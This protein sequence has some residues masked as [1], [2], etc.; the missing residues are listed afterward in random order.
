MSD[1]VER[2]ARALCRHA[3]AGHF[4]GRD[5]DAY[6]EIYW[7]GHASGA[8]AAVEAMRNPT[9]KMIC[10]SLDDHDKRSG[11]QSI[12]ECWNS[13]IDAALAGEKQ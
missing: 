1:M 2:V 9:D 12:T 6:V 7:R 4:K 13:M 8:R 11:R 3:G 5:L 10:A